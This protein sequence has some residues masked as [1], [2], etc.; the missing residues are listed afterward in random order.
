MSQR[1]F[2]FTFITHRHTQQASQEGLSLLL[3]FSHIVYINHDR[4]IKY[5]IQIIV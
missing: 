4:T 5:Y 3:I 2:I 1:I